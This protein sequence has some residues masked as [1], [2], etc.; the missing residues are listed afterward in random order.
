MK[1]LLEIHEKYKPYGL[2]DLEIIEAYFIEN[3]IENE[4]IQ[5]MNSLSQKQIKFLHEKNSYFKE[6]LE[7]CKSILYNP[8][9]SEEDKLSLFELACRFTYLRD[10]NEDEL[11]EAKR[12]F[13]NNKI[14]TCPIYFL[15]YLNS[16]GIVERKSFQYEL[17]ML[18]GVIKRR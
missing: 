5:L 15:T 2:T 13:E 10:L 9:M 17:D 7:Y 11:K 1:S 16:K 8:D 18:D 4:A 14:R 3:N 6:D 12:I